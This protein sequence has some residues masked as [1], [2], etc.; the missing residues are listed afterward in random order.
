MAAKDPIDISPKPLDRR[1]VW[2][3]G[4]TCLAVVLTVASANT[5]VDLDL[6]HQMA[7]FRELWTQGEM[8]LSDTFAYTPTLP[9]VVHH[10]WGT[11]AIHYF[12][13]VISGLGGNGLMALKYAVTFAICMLAFAAA[14]KHGGA[15]EIVA[16]AVPVALLVGGYTGFTN[17]RA[18][19][20]TLLFLA[21]QYL[22]FARDANGK[23]DWCLA[24]CLMFVVWGNL[25]G[26][27]V[28]GAGILG[29]YT[30][31][32]FF[33]D[34]LSGNGILESLFKGWHRIGLVALSPLLLCINP[35]GTTYLPYLVRALGMERKLI[36]EWQPIWTSSNMAL[37][38]MYVLAVVV[39]GV[40]M[41]VLIQKAASRNGD[42]KQKLRS[43]SEQLFPMLAIVLTAYLAAKH[44]RH[45]SIFAITWFCFAPGL[46]SKTEIREDIENLLRSNSKRVFKICIAASMIALA[47]SLNAQFWRLQVP[48]HSSPELRGAPIYP[49]EAVS[50]LQ[51]SKFKGNLMAPFAS[52]AYVSWRMYPNV[53]VSID[54]RYEAAYPE[55][56]VEKSVAF[57]RAHSNWQQTLER[58]PTDIV[59]VPAH[60]KVHHAMLTSIESGEISWKVIYRDRSY[61]IF[62]R[63]HQPE[64]FTMRGRRH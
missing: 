32:Q 34:W 9:I 17:V 55:G 36:G 45:V 48:R 41:L 27:A 2:A 40:T 7:L 14:R 60:E 4:F 44:I 49:V 8:P 62:G 16:L 1:T 31:T 20:F 47:L 54:S 29:V 64:L 30:V 42:W 61:T 63:A 24:W 15:F 3:I 12:A 50:F 35:Y 33:R 11:G 46:I 59:L 38:G 22:M 5:V 10:E 56:S 43:L 19:M 51:Q 28:A 37:L 52:G 18:Q 6:F 26:G 57:Y 13:I 39:A 21:A 53:K 58:Y 23:R 25:H